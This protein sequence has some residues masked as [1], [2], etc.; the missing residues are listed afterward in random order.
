MAAACTALDFPVVSGNVSL[1][2]ETE[3]RAILPTPAIGGVGVIDHA[4]QAIGLSLPAGAD[5]VLVG[6]TRGWL[7][8]SLWLREIAG[9]EDGA[10]PMVDLDAE[11]RNGDFVR[12][13][14]LAGAVLACHDCADG[15]LLVTI[16]EMCMASG[17][18]AT[19]NVS[20]G[21]LP[22]H[23]FWFG[24]DQGRYVLA[25]TDAMALR[26]AASRLDIPVTRLGHSGGGDLVLPD[27]RS[28]S[29]AALREAHESTLPALM[30]GRRS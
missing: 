11:R 5:L 1:Y 2:N 14:I 3:G 4:G 18:G 24:E 30:E 13:Q 9:R 7:G 20:P 10:P 21:F 26:I 8:Q 28:I 25:V 29:V 15:G 12:D 22:D 17:I 6:D 23:A 19:L 27:G 16:A